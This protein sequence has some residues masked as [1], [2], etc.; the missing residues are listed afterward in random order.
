MMQWSCVECPESMSSQ[1]PTPYHSICNALISGCFENA[2]E[3][4][5]YL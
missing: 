2:C 3:M 1:V 5:E 4:E